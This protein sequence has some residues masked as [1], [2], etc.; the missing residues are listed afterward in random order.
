VAKRILVLIE[1]DWE[2]QGNGLGNVAQLQ[3]LPTLFLLNLA[4]QLGIRLTFMAEAMQQLRHREDA[5]G[6]RNLRVQAD[7]WDETI[8][9]I[10]ERGH[11]VQLHLHPQ[12]TGARLEDGRYR[13]GGSWNLATYDAPA[14]R[15]MIARAIDYLRDLLLP[16]DPAY[17]VHSFKAGQWGL[18]PSGGIL[19]DL[20]DAGIRVVLGVGKGIVYRTPDF[21]ADYSGLEEEFL[22]YHPDYEDIRRVSH[23]PQPIV[24]LPLPYYTVGPVMLA[25]QVARRAVRRNSEDRLYYYPGLPGR[26]AS[27]SPMGPRR[28]SR[29]AL[30]KQRGD[31]RSL[32]IGSAGFDELRTAIDQIVRRALDAEPDVV[33]VVLQSHTKAYPGNWRDLTRFFRY[34]VERHGG[35]L[36]FLTFTDLVARLD[37]LSVV[38]GARA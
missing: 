14:R 19:Q 27:Y 37:T 8:R 5:T 20:E 29:A 7:L 33:P 32:D 26:D 1:D 11:D 10:K 23:C 3:Y 9:M 30:L 13:V 35:H 2:L 21:E 31:L 25:R 34:L 36:E 38:G 18:Q 16:L 28:V 15:E 4:E 24:V 6:N 22:P 17:T 12:W